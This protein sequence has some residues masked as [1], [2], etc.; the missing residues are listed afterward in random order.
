MDFECARYSAI[1]FVIDCL[2][3][4]GLKDTDDS[5]ITEL[6]SAARGFSVC[7]ILSR[8]DKVG[9][10]VT[11]NTESV[12]GVFDSPATINLNSRFQH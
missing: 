10:N 11:Q 3:P 8:F 9:S 2:K 1:V 7:C 12:R 5:F 6:Q 4:C